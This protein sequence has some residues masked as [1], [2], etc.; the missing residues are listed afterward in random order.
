M[1][2]APLTIAIAGVFRIETE[3]NVLYVGAMYWRKTAEEASKWTARDELGET[4][5]VLT[6]L[7]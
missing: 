7:N 1:T 3:K 4:F 2:L 6:S 5:R